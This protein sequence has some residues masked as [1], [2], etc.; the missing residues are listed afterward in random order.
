MARIESRKIEIGSGTIFRAILILLA[1]WLVYLVRNIVVLL[2]AALI[3][4]SAI[5]PI[6]NRLE[7]Y[8]IPRAIS[9]ILIYLL[10]LLVVGGVFGLMVPPLA[11]QVQQLAVSLPGLVESAVTFLP[12]SIQ[13]DQ[14]TV[15][16]AFQDGLLKFGNDVANIGRNVF[17][18]TRTL[19]TGVFSLLFIFILALYL[20]VEKDALKKFARLF[21][22]A[23]HSAY[24]DRTIERAQY[25]LGRWLLGQAT[26]GLSVGL[27]IGLGLQFMGVPYALLLGMFA[28]IMEFIP[29]AGPVIAAIPGIIVALSQSLLLGVIAWVFYVIVGQ[30]E[31]HVLIPKIMQRAVGLRPLVTII[32]VLIGAQLGGIVGIILAVPLATVI[33]TIISDVRH[34]S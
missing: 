25:G 33:N 21:T 24:V 30:V 16:T 23:E 14:S 4:A 26:L 13:F 18:G 11:H 9:V 31:S 28:G 32:A 29:V 20:V 8:R 3:V 1:I 5:E 2:F 17:R 12:P 6:A 15:V 19:F 34:H 27:I 22:P 7:R 10:I